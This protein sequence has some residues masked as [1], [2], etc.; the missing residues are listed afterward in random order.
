MGQA[1]PSQPD[2]QNSRQP[3]GWRDLPYLW[4][5]VRWLWSFAITLLGLS[6]ITFA[7]TR[8]SPIDPAL[9]LVGDHAS[10]STYAQARETLGLDEPLP[11]QFVNYLRTALSGNLGQSIS[12][13]QPVARDIARTFPAT[14]ELATVA[15]VLGSVFG[16]S[17]GIIG[18]MRPG[19]VLDGVVRLVSLVGYSVPIFWL[20]LLMLL[21]FYAKLHWAPGPGRLDVVFQYTVPSVT[22]FALVDTWLSGK[23]GAFRSALSHLAL[24][25]LV[26]AFY[27]M[28][29]ISRLTRA[30][31]LAEL[32]QEYVLT[33][34]AKGAG[35]VRVVFKH[36]LPNVTGTLL[37]VI[38]LSYASLLEGAV[39]TETVFAWPG[40]GRYLT[41]A[42]FAGDMPAI[43]GGTLVVGACFVALNAFTD[44]A[45]NRLESAQ[46]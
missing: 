6:I 8:L 17:L 19:S 23:V 11:V 24:P 29:G 22:G 42:M 20:G 33:A 32:G 27:A 4:T 45:V 28:A 3:R 7:M 25:A 12:T 41:T 2:D 16:L 10:Q 14:L 35:L 39:L 13:G 38:A 31:I 37:T 36:V 21:L 46:R 1:I 9:Q 44:F 18:A 26:L 5:L 34:R 30:S 43:L 15:I 40:I